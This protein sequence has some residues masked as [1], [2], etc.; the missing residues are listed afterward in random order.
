[1]SELTPL[2]DQIGELNSALLVITAGVASE[3]LAR[4]VAERQRRGLRC[5][6]VKSPS[7]GDRRKGI[8]E[9]IAILTGGI[10]ITGRSGIKLENVKMDHLGGAAVIIIHQNNTA[11]IEGRGNLKAIEEHVK[12]VRTRIDQTSSDDEREALNTRLARLVGGCALIRVGGASEQDFEEKK[13]LWKDAE[14]AGRAAIEEGV[15]PGG[16]LALLRASVAIQ[17]LEADG[18][19]RIG[20]DIIR[21]A[22]QEPLRQ[23]CANAGQNGSEAIREVSRRGGSN[24]FNAATHQYEDLLAEGIIDPTLATRCSLENAAALATKILSGQSGS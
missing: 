23:I 22:C 20:L 4:L 9:D 16:G 13:S 17:S 8:L 12:R 15:V 5:C 21:R 2:L 11:I 14:R 19:E 1:M 7:P 18:E 24:G 3:A 6:V 10:V